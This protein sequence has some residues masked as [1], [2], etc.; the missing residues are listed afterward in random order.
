MIKSIRHKG[1]KQLWEQGNGSKLPPDL[2]PRIERMLE[3]IDSASQ[4]PQDFEAFK[5]W[6][7]HRL[8]GK[9][10]NF[11]SL[12]VDKNYRIQCVNHLGTPLDLLLDF[13]PSYAKTCRHSASAM[14]STPRPDSCRVRSCYQSFLA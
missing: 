3:V 1:L 11:W 10:K 13:Q 9:L 5:N 8:T 14:R 2:V 12:K 7:L 4:L 6:G